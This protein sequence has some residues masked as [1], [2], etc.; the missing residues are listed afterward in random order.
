MHSRSCEQVRA[1]HPDKLCDQIADS[2]LDAMIDLAY[3]DGTVLK[4]SRVPTL[5]AGLEVLAKGD[6]V[7][8]SGEIRILDRIRQRLDYMEIV[9]K[10]VRESGYDYAPN[11]VM[12]V[13]DQQP[14]LQASSDRHGAGDQGIMIGY[15]SDETTEMMPLEF[16]LATR[17][18]RGL[19]K[20]I[21]TPN[22]EWLRPDGKAQVTIDGTNRVTKIVI[23]VQHAGVVKGVEKAGQ[24]QHII[25]EQLIEEFLYSLLGRN[26]LMSTE[27]VVNGT[28][29]FTI[30]GPAGDAGVA[31]RKIVCDSYGPAVPVGGG[32]FSGKDPTKVDRSGA[33]MARVIAVSALR[34]MAGDA[35]SVTVRLAYAI[36]RFQP[37]M[38]VATTN[39]GREIADWV[40]SRYPDLSPMAIAER[41]DLWRLGG[42]PWRYTDAARYGHF[43]RP[44][45]PWG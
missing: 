33:Y 44:E 11:V 38:I 42:S 23:G 9:N 6:T 29:S 37:E 36:G 21:G 1:G 18:C 27:I 41:L 30:G 28:G 4:Q 43:G 45:F 20:L 2:I 13:G 39:N 12:L 7:V 19:D 17:I 22:F 24:V 35:N 8:L 10:V 3:E 25:R 32:A 40:S 16:S 15:A 26:E 34:E 14:E 5:R 31:G